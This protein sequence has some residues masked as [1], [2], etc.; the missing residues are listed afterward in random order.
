EGLEARG[1]GSPASCPFGGGSG[2]AGR[3]LQ[4]V[5]ASGGIGPERLRAFAP[6]AARASPVLLPPLPGDYSAGDSPDRLGGRLRRVGI[7]N[8][9]IFPASRPHDPDLCPAPHG[10]PRAGYGHTAARR[11]ALH[12][13]PDRQRVPPRT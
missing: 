8:L 13:P 11:R 5:A 12:G 3:S 10:R 4:S 2:R 1:R 6:S 9:N 7:V